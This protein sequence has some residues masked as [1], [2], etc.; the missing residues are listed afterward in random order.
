MLP[1][2]YTISQIA[3]AKIGMADYLSRSPK[4]E[5]PPTSKYDEQFVVE[6]IENF[7]EACRVINTQAPTKEIR[8]IQL[9]RVHLEKKRINSKNFILNG[10]GI[11]GKHPVSKTPQGGVDNLYKKI[12][13][14]DLRCRTAKT[15]KTSD[16]EGTSNNQLGLDMQMFTHPQ[17]GAS[18]CGTDT[19]QSDQ[20]MQIHIPQVKIGN[21]RGKIAKQ[22]KEDMH[23]H[24]S[25]REVGNSCGEI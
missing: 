1:F 23:M 19:N 16:T 4:F 15:D 6:A 12:I 18:S 3:G 10:K 9:V 2:E 8:K 13:Q 17:E 14:S 11:E 20:F 21:L 7:D 24:N 25:P 22:S 5:A